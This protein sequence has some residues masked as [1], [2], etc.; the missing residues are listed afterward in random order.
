MVGLKKE[1]TFIEGD[2]V[3]LRAFKASDGKFLKQ[4][5]SNKEVSFFLEMG[6][7]P[8][9][10]KEVRAFTKKALNSDSDIIFSVL[11]KE[12]LEVIGNCG[13]YD[14]DFISK[15]G[16]LNIII[17]DVKSHNNG[18]GTDTV[19]TLIKYGFHRL[20]LNSIQLGLHA[21]NLKALK[22]YKKA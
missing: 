16:Q 15:R 4:W 11:K 21:E 3:L 2:K 5:L 17:G 14:I 13:L 6:F 22:A 1:K 7:R 10:D 12:S 20:G 19:K 8:Y 18:Y 9:R